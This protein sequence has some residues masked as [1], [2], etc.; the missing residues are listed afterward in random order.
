MTTV[1][2]PEFLDV[3][4]S[5]FCHGKA[6]H[7]GLFYFIKYI[8]SQALFNSKTLENSLVHH[9]VKC[10]RLPRPICKLGY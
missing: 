6:V 1:N 2:L 10:A 8:R 7:I 9:L 3:Y 4:I 5:S